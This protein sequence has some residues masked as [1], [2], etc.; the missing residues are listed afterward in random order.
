MLGSYTS[1]FTSLF[2]ELPLPSVV[3]TPCCAQFVVTRSTIQSVPIWRYESLRQW[4]WETSLPDS[5]SGRVME[6]LWHVL[7]GQEAVA[8]PST[9]SCFCEKFGVCGLSCSSEGYCEG[10]WLQ[11]PYLAKMPEGWPMRGQGTDG[12]PRYGW[13]KQWY[14]E[15]EWGL[16]YI[17]DNMVNE[18][19][20]AVGG[21][22]NGEVEAGADMS[23]EEAKEEGELADAATF[24]GAEAVK[25]ELEAQKGENKNEEAGKNS[26]HTDSDT[27]S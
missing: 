20:E 21:S 16:E 8:C 24:G 3:G 22:G 19:E 27:A 6:Y 26:G 12:Y 2:P 23:E 13:W 7:F 1:A 10:R 5:K 15:E 14:P 25:E 4:L 18:T 17:R 11:T 9:Q